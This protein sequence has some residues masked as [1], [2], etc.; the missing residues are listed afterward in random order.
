MIKK[1]LICIVCLLFLAAVS[2]EIYSVYFTITHMKLSSEELAKDGFITFLMMLTLLLFCFFM[3]KHKFSSF[4]IAIFSYLLWQHTLSFYPFISLS[5]ID[6][7]KFT[8]TWP[9]VLP[10]QSNLV[11]YF[12]SM[13][14]CFMVLIFDLLSFFQKNKNL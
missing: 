1:I 7:V 14:L 11:V 4:F 6:N 3:I 12:L 9:L 5:I 8:L 10:P 13:V 2:T